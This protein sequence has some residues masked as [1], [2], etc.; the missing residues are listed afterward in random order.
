MDVMEMDSF[1]HYLTA[2]GPTPAETIKD[3]AAE[4]GISESSLHRARKTIEVVVENTKTMPRRTFWS[5][6]DTSTTGE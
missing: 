4:E 5:L 6:P 1:A 3:H 2:N